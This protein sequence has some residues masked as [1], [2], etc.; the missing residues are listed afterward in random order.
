MKTL[1]ILDSK[2]YNETWQKFFR[3]AVRAVIVKDGKAALVKSAEG[4]KFPGGG[5][6]KGETHAQTL[7]RETREETGL[8]IKPNSIRE[9]GEI[10]EIRSSHIFENEI[11]VQTSYYY[12]AE[13]EDTLSSQSL[14]NEEKKLGYTLEW[15][16]FKTAYETNIQ[17]ADKKEEDFTHI[18]REAYVFKMFIDKVNI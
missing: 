14:T 9:F 5:I 16:D 8:I 3:Y 4:Y 12:F 1:A 17:T 6:E 13:A 15:V 7:I 2:N 18:L 10:Q 11:F